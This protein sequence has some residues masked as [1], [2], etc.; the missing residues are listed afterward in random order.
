MFKSTIQI[1]PAARTQK[2]GLNLLK[3]MV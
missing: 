3:F 2:R 1:V